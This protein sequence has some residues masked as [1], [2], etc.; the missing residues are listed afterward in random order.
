MPVAQFNLGSVPPIAI[1]F[2]YAKS[3]TEIACGGRRLFVCMGRG[4]RERPV[5]GLRRRIEYEKPRFL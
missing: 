5:R 4:S 3:G 1:H 2:R